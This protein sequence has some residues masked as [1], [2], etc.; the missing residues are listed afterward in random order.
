ML[1]AVFAILSDFGIYAV[2][3]RTRVLSQ[4]RGLVTALAALFAMW[5]VIL[6]TR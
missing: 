3:R 1:H 5:L 6:L 4:T 2:L